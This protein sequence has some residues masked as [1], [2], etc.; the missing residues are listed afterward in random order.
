[1]SLDH[2]GN[3]A[4]HSTKGVFASLLSGVLRDAGRLLIAF[5][6][7]SGAGAMVCWYYSL[8]MILSVAGGVLVAALVMLFWLGNSIT[9]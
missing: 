3:P 5:L 8:P 4:S 1:M 7:G 6:V 9:D 2:R